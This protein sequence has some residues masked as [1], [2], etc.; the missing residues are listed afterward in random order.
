MTTHDLADDSPDVPARDTPDGGRPEQAETERP[1]EG[2]RDGDGDGTGYPE[3]AP[4]AD[5]VPDTGGEPDAN[6][7]PEADEVR[8][9]DREPAADAGP[10]VDDASRR[11]ERGPLLARDRLTAI[12]LA[13]ALLALGLRFFDLGA[14]VAHWQEARLGWWIADYARSGAY[15]ANPALGGSLLQVL[16][17]FSTGVL[18]TT[19]LA[20]RA[21]VALAGGVLPVGALAFRRRLDATEV[22]ALAGL[23]ALAPLLVYYTRFASVE[24]LAAVLALATVAVVLALRE[25]PRPELVLAG[26]ALGVLAVT[27]EPRA[28]LA[29]LLALLVAWGAALLAVPPSAFTATSGAEETTASAEEPAT[30]SADKPATASADK[31]A[32]ASADKPATASADKP[33]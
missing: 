27:A 14:R 11:A 10:E 29:H 16:G 21:P 25:R 13:F 33:A 8:V 12:V 5:G 7:D 31:P 18:G 23:L 22:V 19:D 6:A 20:I 2:G 4:G 17:R 28:G 3:A 26:V 24:A 15:T 32:T 9:D 30:A 1:G